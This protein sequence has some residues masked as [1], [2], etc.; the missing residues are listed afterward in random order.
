MNKL[1][2]ALLLVT[3]SATAH[4][5]YEKALLAKKTCEFHGNSARD[6]YKAKVA[7]VTLK[8]HIAKMATERINY[9]E[10]M[11]ATGYNSDSEDDAYD[12]AW[13][14]CMDIMN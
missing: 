7:G 3:S 5:G 1:L 10:N 14:K 2:L 11:V 13:A 12:L 8:E 9:A 6:G 4:A